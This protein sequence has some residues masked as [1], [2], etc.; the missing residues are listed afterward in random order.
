MRLTG[1]LDVGNASKFAPAGS[2]PAP[3]IATPPSSEGH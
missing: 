3:T 1:L 2:D